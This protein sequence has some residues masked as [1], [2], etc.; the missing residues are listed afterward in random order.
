MVIFDCHVRK[1]I[2]GDFI[3][4]INILIVLCLLH[5][6]FHFNLNLVCKVELS[7][8]FYQL[9]LPIC[10]AL[11]FLEETLKIFGKKEKFF[12]YGETCFNFDVIY[13]QKNDWS[14]YYQGL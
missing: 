9:S 14:V 10:S 13:L 6:S 4:S 2:F 5:S 12:C 11:L 1:S 3:G 8:K 7:A